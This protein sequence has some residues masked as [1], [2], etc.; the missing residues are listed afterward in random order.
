MGNILFLLIGLFGVLLLIFV[1]RQRKTLFSGGTRGRAARPPRPAQ[2][3]TMQKMISVLL[4]AEDQYDAKKLLS[5]YSGLSWEEFK[6]KYYILL[7][8][9]GYDCEEEEFQEDIR[10]S[11][12]IIWM[13]DRQLLFLW[14]EPEQA[15]EAR[16]FLE[17][18]SGVELS[19]PKGE[20]TR[21][22]QRWARELAKENWTLLFLHSIYE[23]YPIMAIPTENAWEL[24]NKNV[25][26]LKIMD[27]A[28]FGQVSRFG[29]YR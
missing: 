9:T 23:G 26:D 25:S 29:P 8:D 21:Q 13:L 20:R 17:R 18:Q 3:M 11:L 12:L 19:V 27:A 15:E 7:N 10:G 14:E 22:L 2:D 5:D 6:H 1:L 24:I 28:S 16:L 4:P